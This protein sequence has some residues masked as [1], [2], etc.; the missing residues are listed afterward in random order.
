MADEERVQSGSDRDGKLDPPL[1]RAEQFMQAHP[2]IRVLRGEFTFGMVEIT[3][4]VEDRWREILV[5]VEHEEVSKRHYPTVKISAYETPR[6][7]SPYDD[8]SNQIRRYGLETIVKVHVKDDEP[9]T[10]EVGYDKRQRYP[11]DF[12]RGQIRYFERYSLPI[13]A[14]ELVATARTGLEML[15][16]YREASLDQQVRIFEDSLNNEKWDNSTWAVQFYDG[17]PGRRNMDAYIAEASPLLGAVMTQHGIS[18]NHLHTKVIYTLNALN[19]V[20]DA[21]LPQEMPPAPQNRREPRRR[22]TQEWTALRRR[23]SGR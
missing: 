7:V 17:K 3:Q 5:D 14:Q 20:T 18:Y 23:T 8:I 15:K 11:H 1:S 4:R 12:T 22:S 13:P 21:M 19:K 10:A 2:E 9:V 16:A 6:N